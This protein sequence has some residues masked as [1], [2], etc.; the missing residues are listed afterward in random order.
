MARYVKCTVCGEKFNIEKIQGVMISPRKFAHEKCYTG[1]VGELVPLIEIKEKEKPQPKKESTVDP[2]LQ[3]LRTYIFEELYN[4]DCNFAMINKQ[5]KQFHD[6]YGYTYTGMLKTLKWFYE[7]QKNS[8]SKSVKRDI[9]ILPYVYRDA[10]QYYYSLYLAQ[11]V[12]KDK[13]ISQYKPKAKE[14]IIESPRTYTRPPRL[15]NMEDN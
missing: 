8:I 11:Q 5:I 6:E 2:D 12:N 13:N 7:I 4:K 14:I 15:F 9:A 1:G 10:S 3:I